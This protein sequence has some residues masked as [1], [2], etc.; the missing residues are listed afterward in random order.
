VSG[1]E[2]DDDPPPPPVKLD[3][4]FW[5]LMIFCAACIVGGLAIATLGPRL[6]PP[7]APAAEGRL[8]TEGAAAK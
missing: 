6:F 3:G 1:P 4:R 5:A 7:E 2:D 8:A